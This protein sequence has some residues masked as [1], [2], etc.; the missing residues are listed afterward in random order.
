[1]SSSSSPL[2]PWWSLSSG[3]TLLQL[4]W[5][6]F[7]CSD[8]QL[9]IMSPP[10]QLSSSEAHPSLPLQDWTAILFGHTAL[11]SEARILA[12]RN[13]FD[14]TASMSRHPWHATNHCNTTFLEFMQREWSP[15]KLAGAF[16]AG[17]VVQSSA[18][19]LLA[20]SHHAGSCWRH[21][22]NA[23][24]LLQPC[25]CTT[26]SG[27]VHVDRR[28]RRCALPSYPKHGH[29]LS[30]QTTTHM[31]VGTSG[32]RAAS[33]MQGG[34]TGGMQRP[35]AP[36]TTPTTARSPPSTS[37]WAAPT[38]AISWSCAPG[39]PSARWSSARWRPVPTTPVLQDGMA[40]S[41]F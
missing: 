19:P 32:Q 1:M 22:C 10:L 9:A 18:C 39:K 27:M 28:E 3:D 11:A 21:H 41:L 4:C 13:A 6:A 8:S 26:K 25:P 7:C 16:H 30:M 24:R 5:T 38:H 36:S 31:R 15:G 35:G 2:I 20:T 23:C 40:C 17:A 12:C 29:D 33:C 34:R 14:W 37:A